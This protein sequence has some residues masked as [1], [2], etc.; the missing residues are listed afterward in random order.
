MH[1]DGPHISEISKSTS[2]FAPSQTE[3]CV[4]CIVNLA[5]DAEES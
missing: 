3:D 4:N 1:R 2:S 5:D